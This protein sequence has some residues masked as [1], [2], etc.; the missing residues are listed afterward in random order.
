MIKTQLMQRPPLQSAAA[1][2]EFATLAMHLLKR[3]AAGIPVMQQTALDR[4]MARALDKAGLSQAS[5]A[6]VAQNYQRLPTTRKR[7]LY[8]L[9]IVD[10]PTNVGFDFDRIQDILDRFDPLPLPGPVDEPNPHEVTFS[11]LICDEESGELDFLGSDEPYIVFGVIR[12]GEL[13]LPDETRVVVTPEYTGV[14]DGERRPSSGSQNLRLFGE[15]GPALIDVNRPL[16]ITATPFERDPGGG[17]QAAALA[18]AAA[19]IITS[20]LLIEIP[21]AAAALLIAGLL[22]GLIAGLGFGDDQLG[23][24]LQI[25]L[26]SAE[27]ESLTASAPLVT[28]PELNFTPGFFG[29]KY[30]A[31]LQ[32]RRA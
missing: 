25:V 29:A 19:L 31:V 27:A 15:T 1:A 13:G 11:H 16:V 10:L 21:P 28:L 32:L 14:D 7:E 23:P 24:T 30:R 18:V 26:S 5:I 8:D 17:A 2:R 3:Q 9:D 4:A 12:P 6:R 20:G 22:T